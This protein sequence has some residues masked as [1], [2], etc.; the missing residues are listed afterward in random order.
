LRGIDRLPAVVERL[1]NTQILCGDFERAMRCCDSPDC[2]H[3]LDPPYVH[4]TRTNRDAEGDPAEGYAQE[5]TDTD[6]ERLVAYLLHELEG[7]VVLSGYMHPLYAPLEGAGWSRLDFQ[8]ACHAAGRTR[9]TGMLGEGAAMRMQPRTESVWLC[10]RTA[11]EVK[12]DR[13]LWEAGG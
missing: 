13:A 9:L 6:H 3:Y 2:L 7:K 1:R 8:T 10:P 5:M 11:A 12:P 4:A